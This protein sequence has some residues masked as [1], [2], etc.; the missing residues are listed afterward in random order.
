MSIL[1]WW[2]IL[3]TKDNLS[4]HSTK[5]TT[6]I[7]TNNNALNTSI[8]SSTFLTPIDEGKRNCSSG[9]HGT[10][11]LGSNQQQAKRFWDNDTKE[12]SDD[13]RVILGY[14]FL[15]SRHRRP[16][17]RGK[18]MWSNMVQHA[19]KC[20]PTMVKHS[21]E[22]KWLHLTEQQFQ[23]DE[24]PSHPNSKQ[25]SWVFKSTPVPRQKALRINV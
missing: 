24:N 17:T 15:E 23:S 6:S 20:G 9:Y 1:G 19:P 14:Q 18:R 8:G 5:P 3:L 7:R 12:W 11:N 10:M 4:L 22:R 21:R 16:M 25:P 2:F 13:R